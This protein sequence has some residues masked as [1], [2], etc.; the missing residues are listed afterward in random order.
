MRS[1]APYLLEIIDHRSG[2]RRGRASR[3]NPQER[4]TLQKVIT[5]GVRYENSIVR[6]F[7]RADNLLIDVYSRSWNRKRLSG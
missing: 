7:D 4:P 6:V 2:G 3:P 1:K 5:R